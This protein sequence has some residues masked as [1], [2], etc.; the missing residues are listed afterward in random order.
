MDIL[1]LGGTAFLG[2]ALVRALLAAHVH[3]TCLAR[4][5]A[6][7]PDGAQLVRAD[8]D[9]VHGLDQVLGRRWDAVV[10]VSRQ[11]GQV[12]RAVSELTTGHWVFV[13]SAN[14]YARFDLPEQGETATLLEPLAADVMPD[15]SAYG[16][17]KVACEEA[18]RT[19]GSATIVRAGLIAG[20]GDGTG[21]SGYYPWRFA[22]PTGADVLVPDDPDFPIALIDVDDLAAFLAHAAL[23]RLDGTFNATGPT[24]RLVDVLDAARRVAGPDAPPAR[25][26]PLNVLAREGVGAWMGPRS[27]PLWIG[28]PAW[29]YFATLDSARARAQGLVTRPVEETLARALAFEVGRTTPRQAGLT[30]REEAELRERLGR[31][32]PTR[33]CG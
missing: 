20:P 7:V 22:H 21:R 28:D 30:D 23:A 26:V 6:A 9:D 2:R 12:R 15:M 27:L 8:R 17:A 31:D 10:D 19:A 14:V 3:V 24:G 11:P 16:P 13:S 33:G 18:V 1:V 32:S 25:P 29:R 5:T 4:G